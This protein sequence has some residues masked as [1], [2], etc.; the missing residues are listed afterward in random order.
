MKISPEEYA[1]GKRGPS[2]STLG[3]IKQ[4]SKI[5]DGMVPDLRLSIDKV[6]EEIKKADEENAINLCQ[7]NRK[8]FGYVQFCNIAKEVNIALFTE[9][10]L[11]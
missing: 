8:F 5:A 3:T 7:E 11:R 4:Q 2:T 6:R 10:S 1:A 9:G